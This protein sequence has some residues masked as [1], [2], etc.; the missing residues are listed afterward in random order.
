MHMRVLQWNIGSGY[1]RSFE[2]DP[3]A[4]SS[5]RSID[6]ASLK[7][8]F[9]EVR[10]DLVTLQEAHRDAAESQSEQLATHV[11]LPFIRED[12]Y[13]PYTSQSILSAHPIILHQTIPLPHPIP[14]PE[15]VDGKP[16][17]ARNMIVT[18]CRLALPRGFLDICTTHLPSFT[19]LGVEWTDPRLDAV[20]E[21]L[22]EALMPN[23]D[24]PL[25]IMGDFNID[26]ATLAPLFP[27]L[28][29]AG[30]KEVIQEAPTTPKG[31][32]LDHLL[33]KGLDP[34]FASVITDVRTDH[35][36]LFASFT[37]EG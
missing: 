23:G 3:R 12:G 2:D 29:A 28:F 33:Y 20:R 11:A 8:V 24:V 26:S 1:T 31:R 16:W 22:A 30:V 6:L 37:K 15:I 5:Y 9:D 21:R 36:P 27:S 32:A 17:I 34:G 19:K 10:P 18:R 13:A 7:D 35:F 4:S 25:L 14:E